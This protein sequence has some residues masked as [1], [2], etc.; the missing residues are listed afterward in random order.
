MA[1]VDIGFEPIGVKNTEWVLSNHCSPLASIFTCSVT[2]EQASAVLSVMQK[3]EAI[4][5]IYGADVCTFSTVSS[6]CI[7]SCDL[8]AALAQRNE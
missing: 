8:G 2:L 1:L 5:Y 7:E 6:R 4:R 3:E